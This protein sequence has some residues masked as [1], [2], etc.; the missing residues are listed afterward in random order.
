MSNLFPK[1]KV[2]TLTILLKFLYGSCRWQVSGFSNLEK[3]SKKQKSFIIAFWHGNLLIPGLYLA[4]YR[5]HMLAGFH[6]DAELAARIGE[7]IGWKLLRGSSS[8]YG[9]EVFQEIVELLSR[10]NEVLVITPDGP[11]GPAKIPKPG[12]VRAAQK[13]EVPII[14]V[15]A[16]S[17][18]SWGFKNWDIFHVT[19]PFTRIELIFGE[20]LYFSID[21]NF[22]NCLNNLKFELDNLE[23]IVLNKIKPQ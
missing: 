17:Q 2:S 3:L 5:F 13:T 12:A 18:K 9:T 16:R 6:R 7:K 15:A 10:P 8:Q 14:P 11:K 1:L 4:N 23:N 19:K 20:P 22:D 21:D